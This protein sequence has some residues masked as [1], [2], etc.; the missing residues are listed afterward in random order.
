MILHLEPS[1]RPLIARDVSR[2]SDRPSVLFRFINTTSG[3]HSQ[4]IFFGLL[5]PAGGPA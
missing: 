4:D 2:V 1:F 3:E 5:G